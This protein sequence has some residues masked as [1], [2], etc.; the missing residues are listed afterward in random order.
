MK[1]IEVKLYIEDVNNL[2]DQDAIKDVE[3]IICEAFGKE[4]RKEHPRSKLVLMEVKH[5]R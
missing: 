4:G 3:E 1:I 5:K 2:S